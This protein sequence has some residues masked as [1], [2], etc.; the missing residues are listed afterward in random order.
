MARKQ[1]VYAQASME[2]YLSLGSAD[3]DLTDT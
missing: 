3:A 1:Q 2:G